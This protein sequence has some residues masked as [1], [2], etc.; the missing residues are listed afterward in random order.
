MKTIAV[1]SLQKKIFQK[2]HKKSGGLEFGFKIL[3]GFVVE[4][5]L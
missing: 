2:N 3:V 5:A 1:P 4:K